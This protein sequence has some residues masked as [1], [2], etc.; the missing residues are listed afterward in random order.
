MN[1]LIK[2]GVI[3]TAATAC[4][5]AQRLDNCQILTLL[6]DG[7]TETFQNKSDETLDSNL[8]GAGYTFM[9]ESL[10]S[11]LRDPRPDVRSLAAW[12]LGQT[13]D[14]SS[15]APLAE[16]LP[17]EQDSC[18]KASMAFAIVSLGV[19]ASSKQHPAGQ[20]YATPFQAC[21]SSEPAI[22]TLTIEQK[23]LPDITSGPVIHI[24]ARNVSDRALPFLYARSPGQL[25]S[26][27]LLEPGGGKAQIP[28]DQ[29]W[30]YHSASDAPP[31]SVHGPMGTALAPGEEF[32]WD[33]RPGSDFNMSAPGTYHLSLGGRIEYLDTTACS[34]IIDVIVA[35]K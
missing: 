6:T 13:L 31:A 26:V 25:F 21:T 12:K 16:A 2:A 33:W 15:L 19:K 8:R 14:T 22:L 24:S 18:A 7:H 35:G 23:T 17:A 28:K 3:L 30:V 32:G 29:Q 4:A 9:R 10:A 34:N 27:T 20:W 11:G 1:R 5:G